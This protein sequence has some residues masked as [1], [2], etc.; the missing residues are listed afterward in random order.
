MVSICHW[1][2]VPCE[3]WHIWALEVSRVSFLPIHQTDAFFVFVDGYICKKKC[4]DTDLVIIMNVL[5]EPIAFIDY[6]EDLKKNLHWPSFSG[7]R[8]NCV[9]QILGFRNIAS[10]VTGTPALG[11]T[12]WVS[13]IVVRIISSCFSPFHT[14]QEGPVALEVCQKSNK[15]PQN[16]LL[17]GWGAEKSETYNTRQWFSC[18]TTFI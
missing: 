18:T 8:N 9:F 1:H 2:L 14:R 4:F 17:W 11:P 12:Q 6:S 5:Q 16:V 3:H 15:T 7:S 13:E 10:R